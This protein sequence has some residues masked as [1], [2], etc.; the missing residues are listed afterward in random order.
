MVLDIGPHA[1]ALVVWTPPELAGEEIEIRPTGAPWHGEH[2]AVRE[3]H[4]G[5]TVVH[6]GV[7]GSLPAGAYDLRLRSAA[8]GHGALSAQVR[9]GAVSE[10][11]WPRGGAGPAPSP[12]PGPAKV[13]A[14]RS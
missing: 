12:A 1:G 9:A 5:G 3:R 14:K 10:A 7:F 13:P 6:A 8:G 4:T 2:T 11:T